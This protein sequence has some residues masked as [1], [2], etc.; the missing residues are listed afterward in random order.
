MIELFV[1]MIG[2]Y[3]A[4]AMC[5][6]V[7][8]SNPV[9]AVDKITD[10]QRTEKGQLQG[11]PAPIEQTTSINFASN[12]LKSIL[13]DQ[14][15]VTPES[16]KNYIFLGFAPGSLV[17][18][19]CN[20]GSHVAFVAATWRNPPK[21]PLQW[22]TFEAT[23]HELWLVDNPDRAG[24]QEAVHRD[25]NFSDHLAMEKFQKSWKWK[26]LGKSSLKAQNF[27]DFNNIIDGK[28]MFSLIRAWFSY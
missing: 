5:S 26:A 17:E 18:N 7:L 9:S 21:P 15:Q 14:L 22:L 4:I 23:L 20:G 11:S 19:F 28:S 1:T 3:K 8:L 10:T 24:G 27:M 13:T 12:M 16:S 25:L 2:F 6:L